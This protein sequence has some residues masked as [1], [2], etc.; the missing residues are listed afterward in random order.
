MAQP[1]Q[2]D[3]LI[4]TYLCPEHPQHPQLH[5]PSGAT[6]PRPHP[7]A[8]GGDGVSQLHRDRLIRAQGR[9]ATFDLLQLGFYVS[10]AFLLSFHQ[11]IDLFFFCENVVGV[12]LPR[13]RRDGQGR[14]E[15]SGTWM[16][17]EEKLPEQPQHGWAPQ[18]SPGRSGLCGFE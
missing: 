12:N 16:F 13:Q 5:R 17:W 11:E 18:P 1:S 6:C 10:V 15:T 4:S 8:I 7:T 14:E 2:C 9:D 3:D